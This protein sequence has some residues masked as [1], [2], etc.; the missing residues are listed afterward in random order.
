[1]TRS[2]ATP[3]RRVRA[4][5]NIYTR[6]GADDRTRYELSY[7]DSLGKQRFMTLPRGTTLTAARAER[8]AL[9]G[10]RGKGERVVHSPRLTF[11]T[12]S[13]RWLAEQVCELRAATRAIYESNLRLHLLPR[14]G[15]KRL[16]AVE[17]ADMARLVRDLRAEGMAERSIGSVTQT[18]S[19]VF[20]FASDIAGGM[21]QTLFR[22][23]SAPSARARRRASGAS[24]RR[25][26]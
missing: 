13:K 1:M 12:A 18:A 24:S 9:I 4:E 11:E 22:C 23:L 21:A 15:R 3:A 6:K 5:R 17:P 14:F 16:D 20:A 10:A 2:N 19:R 26:S 7:R 25:P 8:D